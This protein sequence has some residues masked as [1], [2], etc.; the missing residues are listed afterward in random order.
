[1]F[2]DIMIDT[3]WCLTKEIFAGGLLPGNHTRLHLVNQ[4]AEV[5]IESIAVHP[6]DETIVKGDTDVAVQ[7]LGTTT[8]MIMSDDE[9][10]A[11]ICVAYLPVLYVPP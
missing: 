5:R 9:D 10:E 11:V 4:E 2:L 8:A 7:I 1:M 3:E 6:R